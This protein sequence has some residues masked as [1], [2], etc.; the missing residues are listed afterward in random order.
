M[1]HSVYSSRIR[2][3]MR[4]SLLLLLCAL[5]FPATQA[6]AVVVIAAEIPP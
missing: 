1:L 2:P 6:K 4:I 3:A 5:L